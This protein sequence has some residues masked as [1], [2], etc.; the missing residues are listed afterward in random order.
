M[1]SQSVFA[2]APVAKRRWRESGTGRCSS[3][4]QVLVQAQPCSAGLTCVKKCVASV[5]QEGL[6]A[7]CLVARAQVHTPAALYPWCTV[8][9]LENSYGTSGHSHD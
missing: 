5:T 4:M 7:A 3:H 1:L 9:D 2:I 8:G 6:G